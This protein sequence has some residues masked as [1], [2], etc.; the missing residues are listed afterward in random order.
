MPKTLK[1]LPIVGEPWHSVR[2]STLHGQGVFAL[3]DIPAGTKII[4]Y[5]G[6]RITTEQADALF[7]VNPDDPFHTFFFATSNGLIIDGGQQGNDAR[8]INHSC[9]PNCETQENEEGTRVFIYAIKD[10]KKGEELFYDY[11]LILDGRITKKR[12]AEYRCLCGTPNCRGTMLALKK[13]N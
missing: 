3:K 11:S 9:T 12:K 8:W 7:P 2:Q 10:I 4:E 5:G 6:K 13:S 1:P